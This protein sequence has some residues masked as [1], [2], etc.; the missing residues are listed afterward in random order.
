MDHG[1]EVGPVR[2]WHD[3]SPKSGNAD[4]LLAAILRDAP[5]RCG[6]RQDEVEDFSQ[7]Q[8][9]LTISISTV[10]RPTPK[11][12]ERLKRNAEIEAP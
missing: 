2:L 4:S 12:N 9:K 1:A 3:R 8:R 5:Q 11:E 6:A 7:P 10:V